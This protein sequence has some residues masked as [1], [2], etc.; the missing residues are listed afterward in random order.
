MF[1]SFTDRV[2]DVVTNHTSVDHFG[3]DDSCRVTDK[4]TASVIL[5]VAVVIAGVII[6]VEVMAIVGRLHVVH[7][8]GMIAC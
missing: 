8:R 1:T 3:N 6:I 2:G 7:C 5:K 4:G